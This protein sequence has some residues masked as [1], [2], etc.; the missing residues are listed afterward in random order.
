MRST[1]Q[2][3]TPEPAGTGG[4][5]KRH[6]MQTTN[7][8]P[9]A[10]PTR[11]IRRQGTSALPSYRI[12]HTYQFDRERCLAGLRVAFSPKPRPPFSGSSC[13]AQPFKAVT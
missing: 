1:Q 13:V 5:A 3:Q 6:D 4:R 2:K 9:Q 10:S 8:Q 11:R 7:P 12:E